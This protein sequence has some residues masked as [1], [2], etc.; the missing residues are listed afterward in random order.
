[1]L[2]IKDPGLISCIVGWVATSLII[3]YLS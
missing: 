2:L 1:V 3:L